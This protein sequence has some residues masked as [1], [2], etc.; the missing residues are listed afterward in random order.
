MDLDFQLLPNVDTSFILN[1][2]TNVRIKSKFH[3]N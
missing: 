1:D 2:S 3:I